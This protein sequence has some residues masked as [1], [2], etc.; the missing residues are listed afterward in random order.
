VTRDNYFAS[1]FANGPEGSKDLGS[2]RE[3]DDAAAVNTQT[4]I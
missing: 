1:N 2:S 4:T 3:R